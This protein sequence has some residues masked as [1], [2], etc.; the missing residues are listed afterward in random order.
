M[1]SF[2]FLSI[3]DG[4]LVNDWFL[5]VMIIVFLLMLVVMGPYRYAFAESISAMFRFRNPDGDVSYPFMST[6]EYVLVFILACLGVG[7]SVSIYSHDMMQEGF[8][9]VFFLLWYT[10]LMVVFF[11]AKLLLYTIVNKYLYKRQIITI[12]PSRWNC[13]FVMSFAVA[14][15]FIL[16]FSFAVLFLNIHLIV[17]LIF[18]YLMRLLV[19]AGRIFKIKTTLFKNKRSNSGFIVYLCAFEIIP[20]LVEYL[21]SGRLFGLI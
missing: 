15:F 12:K 13:F 17:L 8:S 10:S 20:I 2:P 14:G 6:L 21:V 7:I 18:A 16:L 9:Q 5:S 19:V 4:L 3:T 11:L 1:K